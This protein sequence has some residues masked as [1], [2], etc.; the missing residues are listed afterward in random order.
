MAL[1]ETLMPDTRPTHASLFRHDQ[2][3]GA[4]HAF[5][6]TKSCPG[7]CWVPAGSRASTGRPCLLAVP[8]GCVAAAQSDITMSMQEMT[9]KQ[10]NGQRLLLQQLS[11][12]ASTAGTGQL[13]DESLQVKINTERHS[14]LSQSVLSTSIWLALSLVHASF[15]ARSV[16]E[17]ALH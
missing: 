15:L 14:P 13:G 12:P 16:K 9:Q 8:L 2:A 10:G 4:Q 7:T 6:H 17:L 1:K 11:S 3:G 5:R